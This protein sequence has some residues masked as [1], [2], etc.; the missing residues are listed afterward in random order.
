MLPPKPPG[1]VRL[2]PYDVLDELP[3][4]STGRA[5]LVS[6]GPPPRG[7]YVAKVLEEPAL[8]HPKFLTM[9]EA[10]RTS[11]LA[12]RHT[13]AAQ[14]RSIDVRPDKVVIM[15]DMIDGMPLSALLARMR[16]MGEQLPWDVVVS[17]GVQVAWALQ[18]AHAR[19]WREGT[20]EGL[21]H[22]RLGPDS[23]YVQ[24]DGYVR[25]LGVGIG[26]ARRCLPPKLQTLPYLAPELTETHRLTPQADVY[27]LGVT[28]YDA[29]RGRRTF[30]RATVDQ[31]RH[32][33]ATEELPSLADLHLG[34]PRAVG[35]LVHAM[36]HKVPSDRPASVGS[37]SGWLKDCLPDDDTL[38]PPRLAE[39]MRE[40]FSDRADLPRRD[41]CRLRRR[42]GTA[43]PERNTWIP[44]YDTPSREDEELADLIDRY[45][46]S[47]R[48][49]EEPPPTPISSRIPS[50]TPG[51][52][53]PPAERA[54][55]GSLDLIDDPY[56]SDDAL[57]RVVT[58][59]VQA[60][61]S[62]PPA[63]ASGR[64]EPARA[65]PPRAVST[66]SQTITD[67]R[68]SE[69]SRASEQAPEVEPPPAF[70][71]PAGGD[72]A[73]GEFEVPPAVLSAALDTEATAHAVSVEAD[74]VAAAR[75]V[76][77]AGAIT[78]PNPIGAQA[79]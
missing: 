75:S 47:R 11:A 20:S 76:V 65:P 48:L 72:D 41:R 57:D 37:V 4:G 45:V 29:I 19:P 73:S 71:P 32:A 12:Y 2:G 55:Y 53:P 21:Y 69:V 6:D 25:V 7:E 34:I 43:A 5:F 1:L 52:E 17:L 24:Y 38:Y 28:L 44:P 58:A 77:A 35:D 67:T 46:P 60:Q 62:E 66:A 14:L 68:Y 50:R 51:A 30:E 39:I 3:P 54:D 26:R 16:A 59:I 79:P 33:V 40:H 63:E 74:L 31:T 8:L 13:F 42:L 78:Y 27:A 61:R 64:V 49:T 36:T 23:I 56:A 22:G 70:P 9:L 18:A 10:E 15:S